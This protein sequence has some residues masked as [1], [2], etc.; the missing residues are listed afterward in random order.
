MLYSV[1]QNVQMSKKCHRLHLCSRGLILESRLERQEAFFE[2]FKLDLV[3]VLKC[4]TQYV[5]VKN[6]TVQ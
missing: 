5:V 3:S 4:Q 6:F 2:N 1:Q